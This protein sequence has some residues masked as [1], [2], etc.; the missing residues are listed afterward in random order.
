ML[1]IASI[2]AMRKEVF[3]QGRTFES[4]NSPRAGVKAAITILQ[5]MVRKGYFMREETKVTATP[6]IA[7]KM[8]IKYKEV[9]GLFFPMWGESNV[10]DF[11]TVGK[12]GHRWMSILM[13]HDRHLYNQYF[14]DGTLI[15][16][17]KDIED[18]CWELHDSMTE[19][20]KKSREPYTDTSDSMWMIFR[21]Q[22][23]EA[24]VDEIINADLYEMIDYSKRMR[25]KHAKADMAQ[26]L[27]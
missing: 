14:L 25:L 24:T 18:Y 1:Y 2:E 11:A 13:E 26:A 3:L 6:T 20:L 27:E 10:E 21:I 15:V 17:A 22:E 16:K 23:I 19:K 4:S 9:D 7:E 12:Y 8:G 5:R